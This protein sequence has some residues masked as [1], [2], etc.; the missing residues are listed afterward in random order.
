MPDERIAVARLTENG[1]IDMA[2]CV[3]E[4]VRELLAHALHEPR[5][6]AHAFSLRAGLEGFKGIGALR[7]HTFEH[8]GHVGKA[9]IG[10]VERK[11]CGG[12]KGDADE[13][14][15]MLLGERHGEPHAGLG[16]LCAVHI[17]DNVVEPHRLTSL[18]TILALGFPITN[19]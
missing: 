4:V 15:A 13:M 2:G 16:R 1:Q 7:L 18:V 8:L 11:K 6:G 17:D 5:L 9:D 12:S 19:S 14:R 10:A 3:R